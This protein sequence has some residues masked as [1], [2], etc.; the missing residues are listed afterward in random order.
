ML[1]GQVTGQGPGHVFKQ[2]NAEP[3]TYTVSGTALSGNPLERI[4]IIVNGVVVQ[5]LTPENRRRDQGGHESPFEAAVKID[6]SSW[7]AVRCFEDRTDRRIRFAHTG[8]VHIEVPNQPL[9]PR[10]VEI[11]YLIK[12]VEDQLQRSGD[13]L[14]A[15]ALEEYREGLQIYQR[16]A[17]TAR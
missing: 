14:P 11:E 8:P 16:I 4:D 10:K 1:L 9:R 15:A 13:V 6:G 2:E 3:R 7:I 5:K 17:K 12:R